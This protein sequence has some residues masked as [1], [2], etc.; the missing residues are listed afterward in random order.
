[1]AWPN[2]SASAERKIARSGGVPTSSFLYRS[3]SLLEAMGVAARE[4]RLASHDGALASGAAVAKLEIDRAYIELRRAENLIVLSAP[5]PRVA[6]G[7]V[8]VPGTAVLL[9][10]WVPGT[11]N[12]HLV[13]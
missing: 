10:A 1:M 12:E 7:S 2:P 9:L 4:L 6:S 8:H 11:G 13:L 5:R 3:G